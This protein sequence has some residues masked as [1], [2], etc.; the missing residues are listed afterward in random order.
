MDWPK[1]SIL[2]C[3]WTA[4]GVKVPADLRLVELLSNVFRVDQVRSLSGD[5][6]IL[7]AV[8]YLTSCLSV[9]HGAKLELAPAFWLE[10]LVARICVIAKKSRWKTRHA[11]S[12][13]IPPP[14]PP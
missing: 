10:S 1:S 8:S 5:P 4:V 3:H 11:Q 2:T 7:H 12:C 14:S 9:L 6:H 13:F